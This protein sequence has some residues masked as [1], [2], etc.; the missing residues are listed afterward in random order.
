MIKSNRKVGK[1]SQKNG[2]ILKKLKK[3]AKRYC[4]NKKIVL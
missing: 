2:N 4:N 3:I 1:M